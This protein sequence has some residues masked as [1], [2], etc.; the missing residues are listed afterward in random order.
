MRIAVPHTHAA[1]RRRVIAAVALLLATGLAAAATT[2]LETFLAN[3]AV[4]AASTGVYIADLRTGAELASHLPDSA[5][6]PA[7]TMKAV[8]VGALMH[9]APVS[10]RFHTTVFTAGR[11]NA[12]GV[13]QGN[14]IIN[15]DGDPTLN[16]D[17]PPSSPDFIAEIIAA[18]RSA[19]VRAIDGRVIIDQSVFAGPAF[20]P[21]WQRTD[22]AH[23]YGAGAFG[24]NFGRNRS[25]TAAVADPAAGFL[26]RL[27]KALPDAGI[28]LEKR[29]YT[30]GGRRLILTHL[31][32]PLDE[33]MR[34]CMMRSDNL[35]A[36]CLLR[37]LAIAR[38]RPG[39]ASDGAAESYNIWRLNGAPMQ[40][41]A[42]CDG[43]GL[44]RNDRVTP[45]FLAHVL[46]KMSADPYYVS[47]FPLAGTQGT[48]RRFL[49]G[50]PLE[51]YVALKTG[52][53]NAVQAY[54]GYRLDEDYMPTHI[55]VV[56]AN[57]ISS[58]PGLRAAVESLLIHTLK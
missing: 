57:G 27:D 14:V 26:S 47:F 5:R 41:V 20:P 13:L 10:D 23:D 28:T 24:F 30:G 7:S 49:A 17:R 50:T 3:P 37:R 56:I 39:S 38:G 31:S 58:R 43:S 51:N 2:P 36:E 33:I 44:S 53:L 40:G 29:G 12:D 55:V 21:G 48:L 18:L 9:A 42:I 25:G 34:S 54:A 32:A 19:G 22:M 52:S 8:T 16:S 45:R 1:R 15:A 6:I 11:I 46:R 4:P 35:Y